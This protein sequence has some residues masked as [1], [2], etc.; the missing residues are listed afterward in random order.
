MNLNLVTKGTNMSKSN[1]AYRKYMERS[2]KKKGGVGVGEF[3]WLAR[4]VTE[5]GTI[6]F[7]HIFL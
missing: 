7:L 6:V 4:R 2:T 1:N 5:L 3:E